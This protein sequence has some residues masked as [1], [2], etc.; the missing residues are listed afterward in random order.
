[1]NGPTIR[2]RLSQIKEYDLPHYVAKGNNLP[3][4]KYLTVCGVLDEESPEVIFDRIPELVV[5]ELK[6]ATHHNNAS[7]NLSLAQ[8][9]SNA[10]GEGYVQEDFLKK[11]GDTSTSIIE[12]ATISC[13]AFYDPF[14]KVTHYFLLPRIK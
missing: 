7:K 1:M 11:L 14:Y 9:L 5:N 6:L 10:G 3:E 13:H 8:R 4:D 2:E 12:W